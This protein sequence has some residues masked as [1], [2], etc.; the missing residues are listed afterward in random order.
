MKDLFKTIS[1]PSEGLYKDR[2]S[3]F[4]AF[5]Y[6]V[7]SEIGIRNHLSDMRKKYHDARHH[8]YAWRLGADMNHYRVNDD[9]EPSNSAGKP[10]FGQ[11]QS[12]ELTNVLVIVVRYFGGT[13]LG[14]GGLIKAYRIAASEAL[15]RTEI[16]EQ[17]VLTCIKLGFEYGQMSE[18]MKV[19]KDHRL[20]PYQQQFDKNCSLE[21]KVWIREEKMVTDK[22]NFIKGCNVKIIS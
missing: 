11:L 22:L 14:V 20:K 9:G 16:I 4:L 10:I 17:K 8:C 18:V 13:L 3:K 5:A 1:S 19:I 2:G 7:D 21:L 15:D 12:R 6:P